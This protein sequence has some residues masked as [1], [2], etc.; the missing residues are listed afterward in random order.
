MGG[1]PTS[2]VGNESDMRHCR[3]REKLR[4]VSVHRIT[5][6]KTLWRKQRRRMRYMVPRKKTLA[7]TAAKKSVSTEEKKVPSV[8][9][10]KRDSRS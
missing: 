4:R 1:V 6:R 3:R 5:S 9:E 2:T 8:V 7:K 10:Q